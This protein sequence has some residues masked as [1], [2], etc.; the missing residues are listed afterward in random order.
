VISFYLTL[1]VTTSARFVLVPWAL[2][3]LIL[4]YWRSRSF[5]WFFGISALVFLVG[6]VL[7]TRYASD[8]R[9]DGDGTTIISAAMLMGIFVVFGFLIFLV[10]GVVTLFRKRH[11]ERLESELETY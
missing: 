5:G 9:V 8:P 2:V 6:A 7:V 11:L 3:G 1:A 10:C 4:C